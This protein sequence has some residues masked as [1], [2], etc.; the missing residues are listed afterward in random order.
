MK[1]KSL[2][3]NFNLETIK[4]TPTGA[5]LEITF[6]Q[7]DR[8]AAWELYIEMLTRITTQALPATHGDEATALA[9]IHGLFPTTREILRHHG[10][11]ALQF[12]K[13]AVPVLN[14]VVRP[15]TSKWHR[16]QLAGAFDEEERCREFRQEL[17][18]LQGRLRSYN[19]MLAHLAN[20]EDLSNLE[21]GEKVR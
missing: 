6:Q 3:R 9:S 5:E 15:F 4:L 20:V 19:S 10:R 7:T 2:F 11:K 21:E 16:A 13:V 14:Q 8:D 17:L 1:L 18:A 12:T